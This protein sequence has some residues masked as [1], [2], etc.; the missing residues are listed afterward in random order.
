M[1]GP[2]MFC[3][4][5]FFFYGAFRCHFAKTRQGHSA[6]MQKK[7]HE[8]TTVLNKQ[9]NALYCEFN[10]WLNCPLASFEA[11]LSLEKKP[12]IRRH[13]GTRSFF[14]FYVFSYPI[15]Q[16]CPVKEFIF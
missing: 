16:T 2:I 1:R 6:E 12:T 5:K 9:K 13:R 3:P 8:N 10:C 11:Q 14:N 4:T 15:G 7:K